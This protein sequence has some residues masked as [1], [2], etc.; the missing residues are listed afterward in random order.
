MT[1]TKLFFAP[2]IL[3]L[4]TL[5]CNALSTQPESHAAP[6]P[7][8]VIE[9]TTR[10][11]NPPLTEAE[12]PRVSLEDAKA[13]FDDG[14]AVIVDV[15]SREAYAA[16]HIP[17]AINIQLGEF[18]TAPSTIDLPKDAWIITYCT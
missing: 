1:N 5:A 10:P 17:G 16:G 6:T 14:E 11:N 7:V 9:S 18:E 8:I 13:A 12:V 15:R 3:I 2:S 4:V